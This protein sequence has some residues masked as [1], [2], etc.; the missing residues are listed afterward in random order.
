MPGHV[1]KAPGR[2]NIREQLFKSPLPYLSQ[3]FGQTGI[4]KQC[5]L[6]SD[7]TERGVGSEPTLLVIHPSV[8]LDTCST[9]DLFQF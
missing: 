8:F 2:E 5:R 3:V 4:N 9:L 1:M 6:R 7:T